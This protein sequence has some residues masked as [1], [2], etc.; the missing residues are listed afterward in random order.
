MEPICDC[1]RTL[2]AHPL[3]D[4][5]WLAQQQA[6]GQAVQDALQEAQVA[7]RQALFRF[8]FSG[9]GVLFTE[10]VKRLYGVVRAIDRNWNAFAGY[11]K[12]WRAE[13]SKTKFREST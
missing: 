3:G 7:A 6:A 2:S 11:P 4:C 1:G 8:T 9:P 5:P 12:P 13:A 10:S